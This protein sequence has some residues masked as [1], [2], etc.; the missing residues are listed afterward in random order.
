MIKLRIEPK[1]KKIFLFFYFI[2]T[3]ILQH[4]NKSQT[5]C[6]KKRRGVTTDNILY[7]K[8]QIMNMIINITKNVSL[9]LCT[10][11][12]SWGE[13]N[14][15]T[16]SHLPIPSSIINLDLN[17]KVSCFFCIVLQVQCFAYNRRRNKSFVCLSERLVFG[18]GKFG[19]Q[20]K[21]D[22]SSKN[23]STKCRVP[24]I[25]RPRQR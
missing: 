4:C 11:V 17:S 22:D 14:I 9:Q 16:S 20:G 6:N 24:A 5:Q 13:G 23:A 10:N 19:K 8:Q 15:V 21:Q 25:A 1:P 7:E 12:Y 3:N 2:D 18:V